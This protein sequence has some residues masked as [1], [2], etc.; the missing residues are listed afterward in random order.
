MAGT[1]NPE[2][3]P[4]PRATYSSWMLADGAPSAWLA[5]QMIQRAAFGRRVVARERGRPGEVGGGLSA[6]PGLVVDDE[7]AVGEVGDAAQVSD[8][9]GGRFGDERHAA[10]LSCWCR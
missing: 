7:A 10:A 5:S 8:E 3:S 9:V 2:T 1:V 4:R 6:E